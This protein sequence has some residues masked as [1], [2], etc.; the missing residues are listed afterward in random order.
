MSGVV[1]R[2]PNCGT[3]Q[4]GT[5]EC[6]ACHEAQVAYYCTNHSP[7]RWLK[8]PT[9]TQC[10]AEFGEASPAIEVAASTRPRPVTSRP[11]PA[12][13]L[14]PSSPSPRSAPS[15]RPSGSVP[16]P[17]GTPSPTPVHEDSGVAERAAMS[18]RLRNILMRGADSRPPTVRR[19]E[20]LDSLPPRNA[21]AG[22]IRRLM[23]LALF[24]FAAMFLLTLLSGG[25]MLQI[26]LSI[27][28]NS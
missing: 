6:E 3:T 24:L 28:L 22:L 9:C 23:M 18:R 10:G 21:A 19:P 25:P 7:G 17:T 27:L 11:E 14:D 8:A 20:V 15:R 1:L 5:G 26:L 13:E 16:R 4:A 12:R 2:C